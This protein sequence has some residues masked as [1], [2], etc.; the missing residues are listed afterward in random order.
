MSMAIGISVGVFGLLFIILAILLIVRYRRKKAASRTNSQAAVS[1]QN[2]FHPD[3]GL[4]GGYPPSD[5]AHCAD[6]FGTHIHLHADGNR[7]L[8]P[9]IRNELLPAVI[10]ISVQGDPRNFRSVTPPPAYDSLDFA[11]SGY[12]R[13]SLSPPPYDT[14][15]KYS[16]ESSGS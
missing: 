11:N 1:N 2:H 3:V 15:V 7:D 16:I 13:M 5:P 12:N 8:N 10:P 4:P 6:R 9:H 14:V